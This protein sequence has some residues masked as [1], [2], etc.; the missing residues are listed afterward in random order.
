MLPLERY[1]VFP[2]RTMFLLLLQAYCAIL[3]L[4][5]RMQIILRGKKVR[6]TVIA[7]SL[8]KTE[9]DYYKPVTPSGYVSFS[10]SYFSSCDHLHSFVFISTRLR[11]SLLSAVVNGELPFR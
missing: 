8:A 5:P 11:I 7:K 2:A 6:T 10:V 4:K 3:Y 1:F 9:V